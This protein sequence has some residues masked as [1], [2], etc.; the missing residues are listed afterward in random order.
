MSEPVRLS[1][2]EAEAL[3][4]EALVAS[5]TSPANARPTARALVAAEADGQAGHGLSRVPSYALQARAGKVDGRATPRRRAR[6]GRRAARGWRLR[7]RLSGHRP[8]HRGPGAARARAAASPS[9]PS[10]ARII[11][12]RPARTPSAS[13]RAASSRSCSATRRRR[14]PSGAAARPMLGTNPLAFAAPLPGGAD[15]LVIDLAMSVAA[16]GKIVAAE[17]AGKPIPA[18]WAVDATGNPTT[19]PKAALGGHAAADRRRQGRR[20]GA[21]DRDPRR[22][23][24]RQRLRLGGELVLRRQGRSAEHGARADRDRRRAAVRRRLRRAHGDAARGHRGRAGRP[25]AG[26]APPRE[27]RPRGRGGPRDP[28]RAARRDLRARSS[29]PPERSHLGDRPCPR[30]SS[31]NSWTRP[32]SARPSPGATCS[33][34]RSSW[35][36]P[37]GS[38]AAVREAR[39]LIVR[40]RTQVRG[41]LLD[42]AVAA[43]GG[44]PPR[45]RSRQHRRAPPARRAASRCTRRPAPTTCRCAEYVITAALMLLRRAWFATGARRGGRVAAHRADGS[46]DRRQAPRA[47]RLRRRSRA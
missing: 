9:R 16:R 30:S 31:A 4:C 41:A 8:R 11:S 25:A 36:M 13:R 3:A 43:R 6:R 10:T 15:P 24:D 26:H 14:W 1:L 42:A 17:K 33:T 22:R 32:P 28:G 5:R 19:D 46:R 12:A 27:P 47:R 45:R 34:T 40:N 2:A 35:T 18:D 7:L 37:R 23:G 21:D 39:A 20:A 44:R 38:L 29:A